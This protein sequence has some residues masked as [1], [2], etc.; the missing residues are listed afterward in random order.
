MTSA[1]RHEVRAAHASSCRL[2]SFRISDQ[3]ELYGAVTV[4]CRKGGQ[5]WHSEFLMERNPWHIVE[6]CVRQNIADA[7]VDLHLHELNVCEETTQ[8][9]EEAAQ[10][11]QELER[12]TR[13]CQETHAE[14][15]T[16]GSAE[17]KCP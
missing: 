17:F 12:A 11:A 15:V 5:R 7:I 8:A 13:L 16:V 3:D 2:G 4:Y 14:F 6:S 1:L 10:E 9:Q